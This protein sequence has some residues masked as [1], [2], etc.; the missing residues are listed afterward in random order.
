MRFQLEQKPSPVF[1][2]HSIVINDGVLG[3]DSLSTFFI[4]ILNLPGYLQGV[5]DG[6]MVNFSP[7]RCSFVLFLLIRYGKWARW[8]SPPLLINSIIIRSTLST[9]LFLNFFFYPVIIHTWTSKM[10]FF[11]FQV[12]IVANSV[13]FCRIFYDAPTM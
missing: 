13:L 9:K 3:L 11:F 6:L 8:F 2:R 12:D 5:C 10:F 1:P 7:C 4:F